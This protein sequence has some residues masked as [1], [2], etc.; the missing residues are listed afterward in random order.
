MWEDALGSA[1]VQAVL[2]G[3]G[4]YEQRIVRMFGIPE[5][6]L[7]HSLT[8]L[9]GEGVSFGG[10]E[11]TTCL[12]RGEIE[13]ATVFQEP[14]RETYDAFV[15]ALVDRHGEVVYSPSGET[16]DER[17]AGLLTDAGTMIAT[18][19]SCTGGLLAARL[20]ERGGSSAYVAGGVVAYSNEA[21]SALLGVDPA[22]I[23]AHG[24]VSA[25]VAAA[26]ATGALRRFDAGVG[27][28]IT[29]VAGPG[30]GT[31][32]KPVG[33]VCIAAA[34][35]DGRQVARTVMLPGDRTQIRERTTTVAMH[36]VRR[37]LEGHADV[38]G[39]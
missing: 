30:G 10:L 21:K 37:L 26:L 16:V 13:I 35:V 36:L 5:A 17:V 7:A 31:E 27:V 4:T 38:P 18:G 20:T 22:L 9:E 2:A 39:S 34:A 15:R 12:R 32:D 8:A 29:G 24:A 23:E 1:A 25:P 3:A 33:T 19:E 11:V 14:A 6:E 28:G